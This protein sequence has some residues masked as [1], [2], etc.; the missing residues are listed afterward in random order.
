MPAILSFHILH[1]KKASFVKSDYFQL[2][3]RERNPTFT[4][5]YKE[6]RKSFNKKT[7]SK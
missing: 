7:E 5:N 2:E 4:Y 1:T 6:T 3:S